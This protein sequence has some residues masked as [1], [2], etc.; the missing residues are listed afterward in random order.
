MTSCRKHLLWLQNKHRGSH[1]AAGFPTMGPGEIWGLGDVF[2]QFS[3]LYPGQGLR[4]APHLPWALFSN[5]QHT[6]THTRSTE[7]K[8]PLGTN[9]YL[10]VRIRG[11][12]ETLVCSSHSIEEE[13]EVQSRPE[14][15][16]QSQ[17]PWTTGSGPGVSHP[18]PLY[19]L[20]AH[21]LH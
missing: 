19:L 16:R 12:F 7:S 18:S 10:R 1:H 3:G 2:I 20:P 21:L 9:M 17:R 8:S 11:T 13:T 4:P 15:C 14:T 5:S 6:H